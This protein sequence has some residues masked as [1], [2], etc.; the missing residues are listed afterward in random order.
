MCFAAIEAVRRSESWMR[1]RPLNKSAWGGD[2]AGVGWSELLF[3]FGHP[4]K[5]A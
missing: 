3:E 2:V 5:V 4:Q 1:F